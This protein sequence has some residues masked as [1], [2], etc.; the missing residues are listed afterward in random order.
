MLGICENRK[1]ILEYRSFLLG[2]IVEVEMDEKSGDALVAST[3]ISNRRER[4]WRKMRKGIF[5]VVDG[6][7]AVGKGEIIR[8]LDT[9]EQRLGKAVFDTVAFSKANRKGLPD[10]DD[11]WCPPETYYDVLITAEPTYAGIGHVIRN[12]IVENNG[13]RYSSESEIQAFSLDRLVNMMKL[14][15]P[16]LENGLNVLQSRCIAS[17]LTYQMLRA[18]E[19]GLNPEVVRARILAHEGNRLQLE[20]APDLLVIPTIDNPEH[21]MQRLRSRRVKEKDDNAIYDNIEFQMKLKPLYES[22]WLRELFES[23]GSRVAYLNAGL[24]IVDSRDQAVNIYSE[25]LKRRE[26]PEKYRLPHTAK[27]A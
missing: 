15:N 19:E 5:T 7:D 25:F 13:R 3:E 8:A 4:D 10:L 6:L 17:T 21:L 11:Y 24:E 9:Y 2:G 1:Y 27:A 22:D 26:V 16:A 18:Q 14:V 20:R 23:H 12:E